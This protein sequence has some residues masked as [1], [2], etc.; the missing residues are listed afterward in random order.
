MVVIAGVLASHIEVSQTSSRSAFSVL[1]V[2]RQ[3]GGQGRRPSLLLALEQH[4]DVAGQPAVLAE[5]PAGLDEGHQLPLVVGRAAAD[6][7]LARSAPFRAA[8]R[9]AAFST[10]RAG[11]RAERRNG[12]RTAHAARRASWPWPSPSP[13]AGPASAPWGPRSRSRRARGRASRRRGR[14]RGNAPGCA[15]IEGISSSENSRSSA[16]PWLASIV[17]STFSSVAM[18][19][20]ARRDRP[21]IAFSH[22][23]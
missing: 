9:R 14:N 7:A 17:E 2:A 20:P 23:F 8:A 6:D 19:A 11:R 10:D 5:G 13:S 21:P 22:R 12:H 1:G 15:E 3:E 4:A 16:A 18:Q